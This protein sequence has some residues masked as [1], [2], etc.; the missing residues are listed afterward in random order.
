[1]AFFGLI[2]G[3]K[4]ESE[5]LIILT[6]T[7]SYMITA[8]LTVRDGVDIIM[9]DP[10][11]RIRMSSLQAMKDGFDE[12]LT[13]SQVLKANEA[14]FGTGLWEQ[15]DAAER[16]GKV[17]AALLRIAQQTKKSKGVS[18]KIKGAMAYPTMVL[19][20]AGV[21][22][23]YLFTNT[24]PEMGKMM[25]DLGSEMPA[26]TEFM[27]KAADYVINHGLV[28]GVAAVVAVLIARYLITHTFKLQWHKFISKA[29][30]SGSISTNLSYSR[31]YMMV[32][33]MIEN[34]SH[35]TDALKV[36]ASTVDN[37]FISGELYACA[38]AMEREGYGLAEALSS[39]SSMPSDDRLMLGV[40]SR[41]G[42]EMEILQDLAERRSIAA[43]QSVERLLELM[44]P[45]IMIFVCA[46]VA[47]LVLSVYMPMMTMASTMG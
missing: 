40:G 3:K 12:G 47:V 24:I 42:R 32:N 17:P 25:G 28:M 34:G 15:V 19:V 16:T 30:L 4:L 39:A 2:K 13:L 27:M 8:G 44:S 45:I 11:T 26:I 6:T 22:G 43:N 10:N 37:V 9:K 38:E 18:S 29:P 21:A 14:I 5:E 20:I 7:L 23:I 46:L 41:T 1:M 31:A 35:T 33:D 36:A